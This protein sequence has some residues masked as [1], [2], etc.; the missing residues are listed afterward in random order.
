M[1]QKQPKTPKG[2]T[3]KKLLKVIQKQPKKTP[4]DDTKTT[5]KLLKVIQ[6][7][8]KT[9]KG[10]TKTTKK[11]PKDDT[12]TTKNSQQLHHKHEPIIFFTKP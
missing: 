2:Y 12:K 4:K 11:T 1:I 7:N 6:N 3:N 5:Q 9:S 10:D 8:Q